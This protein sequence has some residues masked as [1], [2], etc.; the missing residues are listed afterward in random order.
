MPKGA[1]PKTGGT[2]PKGY[3]PFW[4]LP[5]VGVVLGEI[6]RGPQWHRGDMDLKL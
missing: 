3:S 2:T 1:E 4:G 5:D 6:G